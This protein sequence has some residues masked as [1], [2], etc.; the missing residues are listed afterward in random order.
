MGDEFSFILFYGDLIKMFRDFV[1]LSGS[2]TR[3]MVV[4]MSSGRRFRW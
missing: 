1:A 2:P 3:I 4:A